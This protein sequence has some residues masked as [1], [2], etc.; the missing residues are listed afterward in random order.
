MG[1]KIQRH[2]SRLAMPKSWKI[3]RKG[4]K[5]VTRPHPGPHSL[6]LGMPLNVLLRDVL[7]YART[8]KEVKNIL[9][10]QE[11]LVDGIRRTNHRFLVGLMDVISIPKTKENFRILLN[12]KGYLIAF[13]IKNDANIKPSKINGKSIIKKGKLQL[14]L[15]DGK[16]ILSDKKEAKVGDTAIIELP[17]Q[18]IKQIIKFEKGATIYLVGGKH[19]GGTGVIEDIK[20]NKISYKSGKDKVET[21]KKYAFVIGKEKSL[22]QLQE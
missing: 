17:S 15:F 22:I 3:K 10:N 18:K 2:L 9:Q 8:T 5:W 4:I 20:E 16:N 13:P 7:E 11:I 21:L 14:N 1:E 6:K 19:I 12:K